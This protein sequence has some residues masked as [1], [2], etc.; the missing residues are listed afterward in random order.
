MQCYNKKTSEEQ[1]METAD[2]DV[3]YEEVK[4]CFDSNSIL[5]SDNGFTNIRTDTSAVATFTN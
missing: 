3:D 5:V 2:D 4:R 1:S